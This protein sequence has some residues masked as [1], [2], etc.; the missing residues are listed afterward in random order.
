M[1]IG[2][3]KVAW[4]VICR[5]KS[6]GGLGLK[7]LL[8]WNKALLVKHVWNIASKKDTLWIK[9]VCTVKLKGLSFW[10]AQKEVSDS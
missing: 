4:K 3:A 8:V 1:S 2:K 6:N 5:P 7:D 10:R 9:W